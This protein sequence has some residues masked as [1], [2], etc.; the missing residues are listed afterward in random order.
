MMTFTSTPAANHEELREDIYDHCLKLRRNRYKRQFIDVYQVKK[1]IPLKG[2]MLTLIST[3]I[4]LSSF[5]FKCT[6]M[7]AGTYQMLKKQHSKG[8]TRNTVYC[9]YTS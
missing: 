3:L 5:R 1:V 2:E 7:Y 4:I 6:Q 8:Y 9:H